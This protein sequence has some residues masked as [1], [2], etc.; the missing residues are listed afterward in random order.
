LGGRVEGSVKLL[1]EPAEGG[2][3][4]GALNARVRSDKKY[5]G[6]YLWINVHAVYG[7]LEGFY[8]CSD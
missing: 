4:Y 1:M 3:L 8:S 6:R 7:A 2:L 5:D